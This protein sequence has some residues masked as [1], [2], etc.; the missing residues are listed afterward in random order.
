MR[1]VRRAGAI[2]AAGLLAL[3]VASCA[4]GQSTAEACTI[5]KDT[6]N[7]AVN[8]AQSEAQSSLS[9]L[10]KGEEV[11]FKEVFAP[12]KKAL[13]D[14][15]E[16]VTNEEVGEKL[17]TFVAEYTEFTGIFDDIDMS[18]F[19]DLSG[20]SDIDPADPDAMAKAEELQAKAEE[21][22]ATA[23]ELQTSVQDKQESITAASDGLQ[24]VCNS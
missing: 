19:Q 2:A 16:Q 9:S 8:E 6:M 4:G 11:D 13:V 5:V 17:D 15:Q 14:A 7:G 20:L 18:A 10:M 12:V 23:E 22:Q 24:E 21:L 3:S 1:N